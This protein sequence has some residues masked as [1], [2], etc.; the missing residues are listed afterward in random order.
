MKGGKETL[1]GVGGRVAVAVG[2]GVGVEVV[3]DVAVGATVA[4][5]VQADSQRIARMSKDDFIFMMPFL[6]IMDYASNP[7]G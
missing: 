3:V 7:F 6:K 1:V 5:G 4:A 2:A